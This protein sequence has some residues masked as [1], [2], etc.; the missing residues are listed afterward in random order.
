MTFLIFIRACTNRK[1]LK[2]RPKTVLSKTVK[3]H[4]NKYKETI[5]VDHTE[6][7]LH[8]VP[9]LRV[10]TPKVMLMNM[11]KRTDIKK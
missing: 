6:P 8:K 4:M 10:F 2:Q 1:W 9:L 11:N 3:N 5:E 7:T